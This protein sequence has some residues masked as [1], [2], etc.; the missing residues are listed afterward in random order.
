[1]LKE[2]PNSY[3]ASSWINSFWKNPCRKQKK[4][5]T[6]ILKK[7]KAKKEYYNELEGFES[8]KNNILSLVRGIKS[9][10]SSKSLWEAKKVLKVYSKQK[11]TAPLR[12]LKLSEFIAFE[13]IKKIDYELELYTRFYQYVYETNR[14]KLVNGQL[15][16]KG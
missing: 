6:S 2:P 10:R 11:G 14:L 16:I 3:S 9:L 4:T 5:I 12:L 8:L 15:V 7:R 13:Q 1:M